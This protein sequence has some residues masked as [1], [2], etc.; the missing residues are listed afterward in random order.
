MPLIDLVAGAR[1]NF[2]KIAPIIRAIEARRQKGGMLRYRLVHTG[3]HY[4]RSMSDSFFEQ[5][6]LPAPDANLEAGSGTQAEQAAAIM[7]RYERVLLDAPSDLC[8][9]VG[10]VTSTMACAIVAQK[11]RIP[12]AHVEGGIRSGDWTMPEE[13]NRLVT[14]AITNW[15]FTTSDAANAHLRRAGVDAERIFFVG[16]TMVDTLLTNRPRF[17]APGV[18][19]EHGLVAGQFLLLTLHRPS[20]VDDPAI[21]RSYLETISRA[22]RGRPVVF[23]V[24]PRTA[25]TLATLMPL[26]NGIVVIEPQPYLEFNYLVERAQAV[27]TDSGGVTE[28]ATVMGIP[29]MTL[30]DTTER[31]ETVEIGTNELLGSDPSRIPPMLDLL[32]DGRWKVG[33]IPP[34]WDGKTGERIVAIL[35]RKL[36]DG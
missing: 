14:D 9:V 11:L 16:N 25:K 3:Q 23:P 32:F 29:C 20:N 30:R 36:S 19:A 12:V 31:P 33:S 35:E 8:V 18:W 1:P 17:L 26:P 27:I 13:I 28:E 4:D 7:V 10:D 24:H 22:A 21:L 15:F 5:L 34:L 6:G 2:M